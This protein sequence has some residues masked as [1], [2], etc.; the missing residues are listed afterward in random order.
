MSKNR[1]SAIAIITLTLVQMIACTN[2]LQERTAFFTKAQTYHRQG[3]YLMAK[4]QL[5]KALQVDPGFAEGYYWLGLTEGKLGN[6]KLALGAFLRTLELAPDFVPA[7]IQAGRIMLAAG[8]PA[9]AL[10]WADRALLVD[11]GNRDAQ[12]M[13]AAVLLEQRNFAAAKALLEPLVAQQ[14]D[15]TEA[16]ELLATA[17]MRQNT[18][19]QAQTW[20]DAGLALGPANMSL[21]SLQAELFT[22]QGK[23]EAAIDTLQQMIQ[24]GPENLDH[25]MALASLLWDP[26]DPN[27]TQALLDHLLA[28]HTDKEAVWSKIGQFYIS[29]NEYGLAQSHLQA[30]LV[31]CPESF[32]LRLQLA[33]VYAHLQQPAKV[34]GLLDES[35]SGNPTPIPPQAQQARLL[36]SRSYLA[37][38]EIK[39]AAQ[40]SAQILADDPLSAQGHMIMGQIYLAQNDGPNA[41]FEFGHALKRNPH[42]LAARLALAE[43]LSLSQEWPEAEKALTGGLASNP[44]NPQLRMALY[45]LYAFEKDYPKAESQLRAIIKKHPEDMDTRA[46]LGDFLISIKAFDVARREFQE[47]KRRAADSPLAYLGLSRLFGEEGKWGDAITELERGLASLPGSDEILSALVGL[48]LQHRKLTAATRACE[49]RIKT[50]A[51]DAM[52]YH[53]L[54]QVY[55]AQKKV[56]KAKQA[57]QTASQLRPQW[58]EPRDQLAEM[59]TKAR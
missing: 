36:L 26:S 40:Y 25:P 47:I 57:F 35:F 50:H 20:I 55:L 22:R 10:E 6:A 19:K 59:E 54:G 4:A 21:L 9:K 28:V 48:Y 53:L 7:H 46:Q 24:L 29:K 15:C 13:K 45:H 52:A 41:A 44:D 30:G 42:S 37:M 49:D 14:G 12:L 32:Q 31:Q 3:D 18:L 34:I 11:Q 39:K 43:A 51:Q 27:K 58:Q 17:A 56:A 33:A 2:P 1:F 16:Y 38:G 5:K 8:M 23:K